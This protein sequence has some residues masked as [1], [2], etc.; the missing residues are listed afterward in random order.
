MLACNGMGYALGSVILLRDLM[1]T[2]LRLLRVLF[3]LVVHTMNHGYVNGVRPL[4]SMRPWQW[5]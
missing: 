5:S 3:A 2:T 4:Q 1:F